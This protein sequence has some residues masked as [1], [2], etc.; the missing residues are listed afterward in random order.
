MNMGLLASPHRRKQSFA[1][2][3]IEGGLVMVWSWQ[4]Y[5]KR[6]I[7]PD[8]YREQGRI[9]TRLRLD[10]VIAARVRGRNGVYEVFGN[11]LA[12]DCTCG[13]EHRACPHVKAIAADFKSNESRFAD[14]GHVA[15]SLADAV[16]PDETLERV[17]LTNPRRLLDAWERRQD[18]HR[19]RRSALFPLRRWREES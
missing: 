7:D 6:S 17:L 2:S 5:R 16:Q 8:W 15:D 14:L 1:W 4:F 19:Y 12:L 3:G 13:A 11:P 9:G 18:P 10:N